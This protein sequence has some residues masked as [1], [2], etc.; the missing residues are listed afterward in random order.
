LKK[1]FGI[2]PNDGKL[3]TN[4]PKEKQNETDEL[5]FEKD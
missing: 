4:K 5:E 1:E 3:N 2:K